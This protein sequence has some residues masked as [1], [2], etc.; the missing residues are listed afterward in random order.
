MKKILTAWVLG[1]CLLCAPMSGQAAHPA[2]DGA[3][4]LLDKKD[5]EGLFLQYGSVSAEGM[6]AGDK[7]VLAD[8]LTKGAEL[9]GN[10]AFIAH[11]LLMRAVVLNEDAPTLVALARVEVKLEQKGGAIEHLDRALK[12]DGTNA[13]ALMLR[14]DLAFGD[15]DFARAESFYGRAAGLKT[16]GAKA[17][18]EKAR[19]AGAEEQAKNAAFEKSEADLKQ[20]L[21]AARRSAVKDWLAQIEEEIARQDAAP[22]GIRRYQTD[23]FSF[24]YTSERK[25]MA[26][27]HN[28]DS[29]IERLLDKAYGFV[30]DKLGHKLDKKIPVLLMT[31]EEYMK[32]FANSPESRAAAFWNGTQ[33]VVNGQTEV[34][35]QFSELIAHEL[36]HAFVTDLAG[37]SY[38]VPRWANEGLAEYIENCAR[39]PST[40]AV[41][42][43]L[44]NLLKEL[45]RRKQLP[46]LEAMEQNFAAMGQG[47]AACY[48]EAAFAVGIL[49]SKKGLKSYVEA[50]REMKRLRHPQNFD[51][52]LQKHM[53]VDT[54]WLNKEV[55]DKI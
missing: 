39:E 22:G 12:L 7:K 16:P 11:G 36:T 29:R 17:A 25:T 2:C 48:A 40:C 15:G 53:G 18:Q 43:Q 47:V 24:S 21:E 41:P 54:A 3:R 30:S 5:T 23:H 8:I 27:I 44:R 42:K 38:S 52:A 19:K 37:S 28:F 45:K 55:L 26:E 1:G 14:G 46:Q 10:D 9:A 6:S 32:K 4:A 34:D 20:R 50:I 33:I 49:V 13:Q 35:R 31:R 51:K